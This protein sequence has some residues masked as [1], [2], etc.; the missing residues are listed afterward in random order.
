MSLTR[1]LGYPVDAAGPMTG[2]NIR[3]AP[4]VTTAVTQ[5]S[6][7]IIAADLIIEAMGL[8]VESSLK[9]VL[10]ACSFSGAGLVTLPEA[11][12]FACGVP[13]VFVGGVMINGGASVVQCVAEGMK[14]GCEMDIF[15][16]SG[17]H[18]EDG[19]RI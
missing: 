16:R 6:G 13:G 12:S 19:G 10:P 8:A 7:E 3:R 9:G 14:A 1:P 11:G 15:L 5:E 18:R 4:G 17:G 2:L